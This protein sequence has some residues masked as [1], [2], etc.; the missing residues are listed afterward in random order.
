M[1]LPFYQGMLRHS[2]SINNHGDRKKTRNDLIGRRSRVTGKPIK[3]TVTLLLVSKNQ[4]IRQSKKN[5]WKQFDKGISDIS[6]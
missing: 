5:F 6:S 2:T 4:Q 1:D 3:K